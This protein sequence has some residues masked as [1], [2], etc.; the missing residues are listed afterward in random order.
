LHWKRDRE[1]KRERAGAISWVKKKIKLVVFFKLMMK[2]YCGKW[3]MGWGE[4]KEKM[5]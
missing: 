2:M 5:H 1:R 4:R 3:Y